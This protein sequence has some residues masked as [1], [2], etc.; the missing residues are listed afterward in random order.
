[1]S[2]QAQKNTKT[3]LASG[4][5]V[6]WDLCSFAVTGQ[7]AH[8]CPSLNHGNPQKK[9]Q[10]TQLCSG[11]ELSSSLE[12][13]PLVCD[14]GATRHPAF[15]SPCHRI[16]SFSFH[17]SS[18]AETFPFYFNNCCSNWDIFP[19][20]STPW[21]IIRVSIGIRMPH[22]ATLHYSS[23]VGVTIWELS[24]LYHSYNKGRLYCFACIDYHLLVLINAAQKGKK[25]VHPSYIT[26]QGRALSP[27]GDLADT[28][29]KKSKL[30]Q[31]P[32]HCLKRCLTLLII[33]VKK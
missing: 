32:S 5:I 14:L 29:L 23:W 8:G 4:S 1:M 26:L 28:N 13:G 12:R 6:H 27:F 3:T 17:A 16:S 20:F 22:L 19:R 15:S 18:W 25:T 21:H 2:H 10:P 24:T 7:S 30:A 11:K 31:K 33:T 9:W